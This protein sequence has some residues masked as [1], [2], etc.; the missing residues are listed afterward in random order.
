M[1]NDGFGVQNRANLRDFDKTLP[2]CRF[3]AS[4]PSFSASSRKALPNDG[5]GGNNGANL[6]DLRLFCQNALSLHRDHHLGI[7]REKPCRTMASLANEEPV[8]T[9]LAKPVQMQAL[10]IGTIIF[11]FLARKNSNGGIVGQK[12]VCFE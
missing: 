6:C 10:N 11:G 8:W 9:M 3:C 1:P 5:S 12:G 2:K 4:G 7:P